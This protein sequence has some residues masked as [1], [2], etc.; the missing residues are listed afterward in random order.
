MEDWRQSYVSLWEVNDLG[1]VRNKKL[2]RIIKPYWRKYL[3][4]GSGGK[5]AIGRHKVHRLVCIAFHG[6]QPYGSCIDHIDGNKSNNR[7]DNLR[8]CDWIENSKKGN[9]DFS[10]KLRNLR[11]QKDCRNI[12]ED[13][14][15]FK[16][17]ISNY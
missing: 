17:K 9:Q 1:E 5:N 4:V 7:A 2:N 10:S 16:R 6:D 13:H 12:I 14:N 11:P 3:Y 15:I 8:W